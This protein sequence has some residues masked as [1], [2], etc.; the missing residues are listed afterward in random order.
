[1][2]SRRGNLY[3]YNPDHKPSLMNA[4]REVLKQSTSRLS[5]NDVVTRVE[6]LGIAT[7]DTRSAVRVALRRLSQ[8]GEVVEE[9]E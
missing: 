5:F 2:G 9:P 6:K 1:M 8:R 3:T 4:V 7:Y